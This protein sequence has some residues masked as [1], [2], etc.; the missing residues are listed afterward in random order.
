MSV[1]PCHR[2]AFCGSAEAASVRTTPATTQPPAAPAPRIPFPRVF[3]VTNAVEVLERTAYYGALAVAAL[4]MSDQGASSGEIGL[5]LGLLLPLPF[6]LP[7]VSSAL[8][9]RFGYRVML[10]VSF[11]LY[12]SGFVL[13]ATA[14]DVPGF[15]VAVLLLGCGSGTFKPIP[16]ATIGIVSP[17][18]R[19]KQGYSYYYAAINV[20]GFAGPAIAGAI[21][22]SQGQ[23][24]ARVLTFY[25]SAMA[26]GMAAL[27]VLFLFRDPRPAQKGLSI[28]AGFARFVPGLRDTRFMVL[29]VIF[30]GFWFLY[31][32]NWTFLS[33]Y[34][35][36]YIG[37]PSWFSVEMQNSVNPLTIVLVGVPL[38]L[39]ADRMKGFLAMTIGVGLFALGFAVIG[40]T[41]DFNLLLLGLVI[42]TLGEILAYP[43]FLAH[44][45]KIAGP[46]RASAY[47]S[48]GFLPLG[49]GFFVGP[50]VGGQL[51]EWFV[52]GQDRPQ[53]FWA[54]MVAIAL[55]T[56]AA[57][58]LYDHALRP[59]EERAAR[60]GRT[61]AA[62]AAAVLMVPALIAAAAAIGPT[63]PDPDKPAPVPS[64]GATFLSTNGRTP[65]G[66]S[67]R[68][69]VAI[70]MNTTGNLTALL[71]WDDEAPSTAI[72]TNAPDRFRLAVITLN[73]HPGPGESGMNEQG[74]GGTL[75]LTLP[76]E[77]YRGNVTF[78]LTLQDAGDETVLGQAVAPDDSNEWHLEILGS[79]PGKPAATS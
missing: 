67:T 36:S 12:A 11:V 14:S 46:E 33:I 3:W 78:V 65:E 4:R 56:L 70:P 30:A 1:G 17:E 72:A 39:L 28:A 74:G 62:A 79:L 32:M 51:Y 44:V 37:L 48:L 24:A 58:V 27:V 26:I 13:F 68:I 15:L 34:I 29:L 66:D 8:A 55:L 45:A 49:I 41:R 23:D 77:S 75:T 63:V 64:L 52:K 50:L 76:A 73:G 7:I 61:L 9:E 6:L 71:S 69:T 25:A 10:L 19:T 60:R 59:R 31:S 47:Q 16:A 40:F 18:G 21:A 42:A 22:L 43:G 57:M 53:L 35:Q 54:V 38:G 20:G 5:V 2:N